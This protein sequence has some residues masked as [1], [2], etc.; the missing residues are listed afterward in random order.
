MRVSDALKDLIRLYLP[1]NC[2][3]CGNLP[4]DGSANM[5]CAECLASLDFIGGP[6]CPGCGGPLTG[7]FGMCPDCM[8]AEADRPWEKAFALTSMTG[9]GKELIHAFKYQNRPELARPLGAVAAMRFGTELLAQKID[10]IVPTPL[11]WFRRLSRGYNQ[12]E[13]FADGLAERLGIPV[14]DA[15]RRVKWTHQQAKLSKRERILNL[16]QAFSIK[17]STKVK[18]RAILLIDDVMTTGS[19]LAAAAQTLL[20]AGADRVCVLVIA[21]R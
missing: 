3:V 21:R 1:L 10:L 19:T 2:P 9:V 13:L 8:D 15:L 5:F 20:D 6:V 17:D 14:L 7:I 16:K 4:F 12:A 11:H 18:K